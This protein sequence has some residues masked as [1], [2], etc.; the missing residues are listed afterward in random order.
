[1]E[2]FEK[3]LKQLLLQDEEE[4]NSMK[5]QLEIEVQ[6]QGRLAC[7]VW[8]GGGADLPG[9]LC[10]QLALWDSC[11]SGKLQLVAAALS[12]SA[13]TV[14][15]RVNTGMQLLFPPLHGSYTTVSICPWLSGLCSTWTVALG[16]MKIGKVKGFATSGILIDRRIGQCE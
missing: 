5:I 7:A 2:E 13:C 14:H 3:Q 4:Y 6:V 8:R 10:V 9:L 15:P 16:H 12:C 1:M 11:M